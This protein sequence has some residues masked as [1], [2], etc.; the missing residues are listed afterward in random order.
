MRNEVIL[1]IEEV[2]QRI[3]GEHPRN[4]TNRFQED[5]LQSNQYV[6]TSQKISNTAMQ[7]VFI[8][9]YLKVLNVQDAVH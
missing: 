3:P 1:R 4:F 2:W 6:V 7:R 9:N 8:I 5:F